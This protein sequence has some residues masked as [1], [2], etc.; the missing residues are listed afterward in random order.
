MT[1]SLVRVL[2]LSTALA[3]LTGPAAQPASAQDTMRTAITRFEFDGALDEGFGGDGHVVTDVAN[4]AQEIF[5]CGALTTVTTSNDRIIA[6]GARLS[7]AGVPQ[8]LLARYVTTTGALDSAFGTNGIRAHD[9]ANFDYKAIWK[10][11]IDSSRRIVALGRLVTPAGRGAVMVARFTAAGAL[12]TTF[13]GSGRLIFNYNGSS[14]DS[15]MGMALDS[16]GRIVVGG[17][18]TSNGETLAL[19]ARI[20][21]AGAF[22]TTFGP[23]GTGRL[24]TLL[25]GTTKSDIWDVAIDTTG[26][27]VV[28]GRSAT[29]ALSDRGFIARY[30]AAGVLDTSF[31][32]N[33]VRLLSFPGRSGV[34]AVYDVAIDD[35]NN[36]TVSGR[37]LNPETNAHDLAV[38][39]VLPGGGYDNTFDVDGRVTTEIFDQADSLS[40]GM[41]VVFPN[42]LFAPPMVVVGV[43]Q[44]P[45][46]PDGSTSSVF[47]VGYDTDGS[48]FPT[49]GGN[50]GIVMT[51]APEADFHQ[52]YDAFAT[53]SNGRI[54]VFGHIQP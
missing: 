28:A 46:P 52:V 29:T 15:A 44:T 31:N 18:T 36:Y 33:G 6:A 47:A 9:I 26:K 16:S 37:S 48:L 35:F 50:G 3:A 5:T 53:S 49:W 27:I 34:S 38:A 14:N 12:D 13:A 17:R 21:T 20:T 43:M 30:S 51:L 7:S 4:S 2:A 40:A 11:A 54:T 1:A 39:R 24:R 25:P 45:D 42:N 8:L 23:N 41:R 22:D 10:V 32:G 19:L